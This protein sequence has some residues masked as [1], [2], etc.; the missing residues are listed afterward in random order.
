MTLEEELAALEVRIKQLKIQFDLFF[1]GHLPKPPLDARDDLARWVKRVGNTRDMKLAQRFLYNTILNRWNGF[2]ELWQKRLQARE[3]GTRTPPVARRRA[4]TAPSDPPAEA[5]EAS[6]S[7]REKRR[8]NGLVAR[9]T[10]RH[11]V[12]SSEELKSFY[13]AFLEARQETGGSKAPSYEKF[14]KEIERHISAIRQK[15]SCEVVDFRLYLQDNKVSLK[16][17]PLKEENVT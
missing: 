4:A 5:P 7:A 9:A 3:E 15:S 17:K 14:C 2:A 16:A 13:R 6:A 11:V 12:D 10:I 8:A 1:S